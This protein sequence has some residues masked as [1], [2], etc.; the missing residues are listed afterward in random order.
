MRERQNAYG[1]RNS[2]PI[3]YRLWWKER[4]KR[5]FIKV[6]RACHRRK[7]I[8]CDQKMENNKE[9]IKRKK[10]VGAKR[11]RKCSRKMKGCKI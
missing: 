9:K 8:C 6:A 1:I 10:S 5:L 11:R 7:V 3:C 4:R 2:V